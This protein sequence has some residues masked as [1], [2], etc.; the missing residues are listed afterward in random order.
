MTFRA[1]TPAEFEQFCNTTDQRRFQTQS[2]EFF[3]SYQKLG[4]AVEL[5]GVVEDDVRAAALVRYTPWRKIFRTARIAYGPIL[6][7]EDPDLAREFLTGLKAHLARRVNVLQLTFTPI[8]ARNF[9]DEGSCEPAQENPAAHA[10]ERLVGELGARR[11]TKEFYDDPAVDPRFIYTKNIAGLS[12]DAALPTL[13]KGLRRRFR[14]EGRYGI[15][16]VM[17]GPDRW[18]VFAKLHTMTAQRTGMAAYSPAM[19]VAY[20]EFMRQFPA[21][22]AVLGVAYLRPRVYI[23]QLTQERA[24]LEARKSEL[25]AR[26]PTKKRDNEL[27]R[28]EQRFAHIESQRAETEEVLAKHGERIPVNCALGFYVGRELI[29]MLGAMDKRFLGYLRDYPVERAFFKDACD[30]G[31]DIYNTFGI[32]GI[33]NDTAPDAP[34]LQFKQFLNGN[35]EEF[36]GTYHLPIRRRLA[37][38]AGCP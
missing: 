20:Q 35:V 34:V 6:D 21:G 22:D 15:E 29:L 33:W 9:Y 26:P 30:R 25:V 3:R 8:L 1:L 28:I 32:S 7:W 5:V 24:E 10:F 11:E 4:R 12:F 19:Q 31:L 37:A 27:A 16:T 18:E 36:V 13:A 14:N 17:E 23:S 38:L 2:I